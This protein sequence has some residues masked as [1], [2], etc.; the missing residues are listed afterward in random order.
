MSD[1]EDMLSYRK[2]LK[3]RLWTPQCEREVTVKGREH[4]LSLQRGKDSSPVKRFHTLPPLHFVLA[5]GGTQV[6]TECYKIILLFWNNQQ[7]Q[8]EVT[9][10]EY[11][12]SITGKRKL[13]GFQGC[14]R[15]TPA[16]EFPPMTKVM[17]RGLICKGKSGLEGP[18]GPA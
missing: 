8:N 14:F 2:H 5:S 6:S 15:E 18:P 4:D 16:W 7:F 1:Q 3:V 9:V 12:I 10:K 13:P 11:I 17:R